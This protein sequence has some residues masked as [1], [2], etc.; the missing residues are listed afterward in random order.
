MLHHLARGLLQTPQR[1]QRTLSRSLRDS[2]SELAEFDLCTFVASAT[3]SSDMTME[4][5]ECL[6]EALDDPMLKEDLEGEA[7]GIARNFLEVAK[8]AL[9]SLAEAALQT[10]AMAAE[11][12]ALFTTDAWRKGKTASGIAMHVQEFFERMKGPVDKGNHRRLVAETFRK[13]ARMYVV[14]L[15]EMLPHSAKKV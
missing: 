12:M 9:S 15:F 3:A 1:Y 2:A 6:G 4:L 8:V 11:L 10:P 14:A 5:A 13:L 7:D